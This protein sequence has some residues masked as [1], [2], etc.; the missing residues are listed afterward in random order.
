[1]LKKYG[2]VLRR[3]LIVCDVCLIGLAFMA[4]YYICKQH[5]GLFFYNFY[6]IKAYSWL[7]AG[8][9]VLGGW[10]LHSMGAYNSFHLKSIKEH[11]LIAIK[12]MFLTFLVFSF[13]LYIFKIEHISRLLSMSLFLLATAMLIAQKAA[14]V[15][16]CRHL[17]CNGF[18]FRNILVVGTGCRAQ[19][20]MQYVEREKE[21]GLK[22]VGIIDEDPTLKGTVIEGHEVLG[23]LDEMS[24]VL[25]RQVIDFA[26]FIV[27]RHSLDKIEAALIQCE[28]AGV[29]SSVAVDLFNLK[30]VGKNQ[31][32]E[33]MCGIPMITFETAPHNLAALFI[34]RLVDI[35]VS[36][37]GL[38][39]ISPLY[40]TVTFL[41]KV[42]SPGPVYFSQERCGFNGRL[43]K[44]YKFRT[45]EVG[46]E[47][48]LK[49]LMAFN[50]MQ[51][52]AFKM[53]NDPRVTKIGRFLRKYSIDELPQLWNVLKGDMSLVGPRPPLPSEVK[54]YDLWQQRRLSFRPGITCIWQA[55]G[56]NRI[57]NFNQWV[58]MDLEYID[59]WSLFLDLKILFKT[60]PAVLSASGAK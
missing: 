30:F 42:T 47:K 31:D 43:F 35:L 38:L 3:L 13:I 24:D 50:E 40:L 51:G 56:R 39:L 55:G 19:K 32:A 8:I 57:S 18:N 36:G 26:V 52:P 60:I 48:K 25:R 7:F 46:A 37:V 33:M 41:I 23:T 10:F 17:R 28:L 44:L 14:I 6:F 27:P 11:A 12:S 29:T 59:N 45:M 49:E 21:L 2:N 15:T 22:I 4:A 5:N 16:Y 20:F 1:M 53:E 9:M 34:K 58:E 54:Q